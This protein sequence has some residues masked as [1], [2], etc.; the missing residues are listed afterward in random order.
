MIV[1][2]KE[3]GNFPQVSEFVLVRDLWESYADGKEANK[4]STHFD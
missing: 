1:I 3:L 2:P 4:I